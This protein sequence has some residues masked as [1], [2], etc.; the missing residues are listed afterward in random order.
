MYE[1]LHY[2]DEDGTDLFAN[3]LNGLADIKRA[4]KRWNEW[5]KRVK[6]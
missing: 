5:Q 1:L 3:W 4:T 6:K 2:Q